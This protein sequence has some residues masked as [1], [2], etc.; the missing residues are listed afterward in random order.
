MAEVTIALRLI[1]EADLPALYEIYAST[2]AEEMAL[3]PD[4]RDEDKAA[5][6]TQQFIA[7]HQYYQEFYKNAEFQIIEYNNEPIGRLYIHWKY[8]AQEVR[9]VDIALLPGFR[10]KGIG[11]AIIEDTF[12]KA[13]TLNKSVTIH[14]EFN[15][16]ALKLYEKLGFRKIGEF[17]SVYYLMEWK[18]DLSVKETR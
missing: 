16:P 1:T 13:A 9:I 7:Q 17:N 5:F 2:R 4:W 15:N 8:S 18:N 10:G 11:T 6:L 12:K 3:V 14:V